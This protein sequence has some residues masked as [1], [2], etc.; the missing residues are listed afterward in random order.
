[1]QKTA[2]WPALASATRGSPLFF[3][4][5]LGCHVGF[6]RDHP[7]RARLHPPR[8]QK[9]PH[10]RRFACHPGPGFAPGRRF[11][12]GCGRTLPKIGFS[13][14][15]VGDQFPVGTRMLAALQL[16]DAAPSLDLQVAMEARFGNTTEAQ[17]IAIGDLLTSQVQGLHPHLHPRVGMLKSPIPSCFD[18]SCAKG[19]LDHRRAPHPSVGIILTRPPLAQGAQTVSV[20]SVR[21]I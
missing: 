1:M 21:S 5:L 9:L 15:A 4:G 8:F 20:K 7:D 12:H 16:L 11:G 14:G 3:K 19:D 18:V 6:G 2:R 10:L 13:H 17:D